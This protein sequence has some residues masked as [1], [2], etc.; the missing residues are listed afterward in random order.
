MS[1]LVNEASERSERC[2]ASVV[3]GVSDPSE[4]TLQKTEL[5]VKDTVVKSRNRSIV[6]AK[7][8]KKSFFFAFGKLADPDLT[9]ELV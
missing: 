1:E 6:L 3:K 2:E 5:P 8:K 4:R 7:K 9:R